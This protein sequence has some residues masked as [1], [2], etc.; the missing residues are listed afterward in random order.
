MQLYMCFY[1]MIFGS[2]MSIPSQR[3][4]ASD[5]RVKKYQEAIGQSLRLSRDV[6]G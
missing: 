4:N 3:D 2:K 1:H 6:L 5:Q